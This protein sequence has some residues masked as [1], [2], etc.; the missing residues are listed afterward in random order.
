MPQPARMLVSPGFPEDFAE[1]T[2]MVS[3]GI[4]QSESRSKIIPTGGRQRTAERQDHPGTP[5]PSA[6]PGKPRIVRRES[7]FEIG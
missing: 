4:S 5:S 7:A 1:H 2:V 6:N 3:K